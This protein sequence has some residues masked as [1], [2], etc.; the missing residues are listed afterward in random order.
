MMRPMC[1]KRKGGHAGT[2]GDYW[3]LR[4]R[5]LVLFSSADDERD[6]GECQE[7]AGVGFEP[8]MIGL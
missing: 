6:E 8:T 1:E 7:L 3:A 5:S 2:R 4:D